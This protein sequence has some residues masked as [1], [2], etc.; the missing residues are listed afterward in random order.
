MFDGG[1]LHGLIIADNIEALILK[2]SEVLFIDI[3]YWEEGTNENGIDLRKL[4][5]LDILNIA[6]NK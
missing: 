5:Y 3:Y 1:E 4:I 2:W 6:S